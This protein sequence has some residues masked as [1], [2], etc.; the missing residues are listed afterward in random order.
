MIKDESHRV[1]QIL[2]LLRLNLFYLVIGNL[3]VLDHLIKLFR[4]EV[5][6]SKIQPLSYNF[7]INFRTVIN[8][9]IILDL[10]PLHPVP[11]RTKAT[12]TLMMMFLK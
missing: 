1:L 11:K 12:M 8:I 10:L 5:L 7:I 2:E 4:S 3:V 6:D 9:Y